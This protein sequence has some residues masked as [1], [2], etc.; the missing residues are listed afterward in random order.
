M[1]LANLYSLKKEDKL[2]DYYLLLAAITDTKLAIKE[3]EALSTLAIKLYNKREIKRAYNYITVALDDAIFYN[4]RFRNTVITR[5]QPIIESSY[6]YTVQQQKQTLWLFLGIAIMFI[7]T[8]LIAL[9]YNRKRVIIITRARKNLHFVNNKLISANKK[10][11]ESNIIKERY[12]GYFM[13]QC[14][15]YVKKIDDL[16]KDINRKIKAK[17]IKEL[18][19]STSEYEGESE[20]LYSNFDNAFLDLFPNF[21][22]EFNVLLRPEERYIINSGSLNTE[23]RIFALMRLGITDISQIAS[24]LRYS[25]QTVYNYRSRVKGKSVLTGEEFDSE[26]KKICSIN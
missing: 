24:F 22:Q 6:L 11:D 21:V 9:Y 5:I 19:E 12:I 3:N 7:V 17:H 23:L 16:R 20:L 4:S 26:V 18:Y 8:L 15:L 2:E 10:L 25:V 14:S 13:N 1:S